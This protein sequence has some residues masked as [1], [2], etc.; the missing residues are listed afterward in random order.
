[1]SA[2]WDLTSPDNVD[3]SDVTIFVMGGRLGG[4]GASSRN[5]RSDLPAFGSRIEE[6]GL[7]LWLG[8]Y[9][10]A[11]RMVRTCFADL[12]QYATA[13]GG[14]LPIDLDV[15]ALA[16]PFDNWDWLAAFERANLVGL[17]DFT[18]NGVEP[19]IAR[20]PEYIPAAEDGVT[21]IY[22]LPNGSVVPGVHL[23]GNDVRRAYP[24]EA[25]AT[26]TEGCADGEDV[27]LERPSVAFF[28]T[29]AFRELQAFFDSL[30]LRLQQLYTAQSGQ[31][32]PDD[33][34][35]ILSQALNLHPVTHADEEGEA[36]TDVPRLLRNIRL[37]FLVPAVQAFATVARI[38][39]GP[40]PYL[41][42][43]LVEILDGFVDEMRKKIETF[44]DGDTTAQRIWELIDLLAA[45]IRGLVASGLELA[46]DFSRLDEWNYIDW[47][48]TNRIGERT[49]R[50]AIIRGAHDLGFAY[51]DGDARTPQIAAGQ[52]ISAGCRFFFMY[53]GALFWRMKAG[54]GDVVFA[55]MY[56]ALRKRGVKFRFFHRL[57]EVVLNNTGD[58]VAALRFWR[59]VK[60]RTNDLEAA[61]NYEPLISVDGLP[62]WRRTPDKGQFDLGATADGYDAK[63]AEDQAKG[64]QHLN[65]ES[66]WCDWPHGDNV[67]ATV[68]QGD[69]N[70]GD[71]SWLGDYDD[72]VV[73]VPIGALGR[74]A[75]Q[76]A[77][78]PD[79]T[80]RRWRDM[81]GKIGTVATQ[82]VQLWL[83]KET[84]ELGWQH[85]QVCFSAFVHPFDTWADLSQ[86]VQ[87]EQIR[88]A[89]SVHYFCSVLPESQIPDQLRW[90]YTPLDNMG[91]L[92]DIRNIVRE[93]ARYFLDEWMFELW[94]G[95]EATYRYPNAF[96]WPL[97][98]DSE[99]RTG[100]RRLEWQHI[101][102]NVDPSARYTLSLPGTTKYR[103]RP[104]DTGIRNLFIAGDWTECGLNIGCVEAAV[105]S[106]RLASSGISGYPEKRLITGYCRPT[107]RVP[108]M[109]GGFS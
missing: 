12:R 69:G 78:L 45:N 37:A 41:G 47:L 97:L 90:P 32:P 89:R 66:L 98:V 34:S 108:T 81:L 43:P 39:E 8:Y 86:L 94:P 44:V 1:M 4:K 71:P 2:A 16:Q 88:D 95:P 6:H 67:N 70:V 57:D 30:E 76:I 85:G 25:P 22:R 53:K 82:S 3:P 101:V 102:A 23:V 62:G 29:H 105:I 60:L 79:D 63:A 65:F 17:A 72:V 15:H 75:Q 51:A 93:N 13:G 36:P 99:N 10:N 77:R 96:R 27:C 64:T 58:A 80:G 87:V 56:L 106:G 19:W 26:T 33:P 52:A 49:L 31:P 24:G 73:T 109:Q 61:S 100:P 91:P 11:F 48:R 35:A 14:E 38:A 107:D 84:A 74:V 83:T 42:G 46:D 18:T 59:Q 21:G 68:R 50:N 103:M 7:H 5:D 20:F 55:P 92:I 104:D 54:M 28:L 9:E 40:V